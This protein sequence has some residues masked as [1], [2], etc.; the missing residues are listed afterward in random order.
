[1]VKFTRTGQNGQFALKDVPKGNFLVLI[2]YPKYADYIDELEI[3]D[4]LATIDLHTIALILKSQL[5]QEV[6]VTNKSSIRIKGDTTEFTADSFKV[7][8]GANVEELLKKLPGIQVDKNGKIT[9]QG[10]TVKKV[11]VDGE[12]FFG[13]D[14]TLVT[15]NLRADMVDKIQVFDKKSEQANFTGIDDGE[16]TKTINL[17]LKDDKKN[18]YFGKL[19][20]G[21][22]TDGYYNYQAM[23]NMFKKK[24]KLA[25]YGIASNTGK[26]GLNWE[27][28][29][30]Y[31][32]S[33]ASNFD[34]DDNQGFTYT[35]SEGNDE[36]GG[37]GG[38][39]DGKGF[40]SVLTGGLHFNNKW[41]DDR[42]SINGNYKIMQLKIHGDEQTNSQIIMPDTSYFTTQKT[43]SS[44]LVMRNRLNGSYELQIDST[45]T[46]KITADGGTDHMTT[47]SHLFSEYRAIDSSLVN[48]MD[49]TTSYISDV[50]TLN[51]SILWKKK[52]H[53]RGR[54]LSLNVRETYRD[55]T[56]DGSLYSDISY[57]G[58]GV[59]PKQIIDQHKS[60]ENKNLMLDS[61]LTYSEPLSTSSALLVNYGLVVDNSNSDRAS[62]SKGADGKYTVLDSLYSND[63]LFNV[64]TQRGGLNYN[65]AKKK[66]KF[67]FGTDIGFT[68]FKQ[69]DIPNKITTKRDFINWYPRANI[70]YKFTPNSSLWFNYYG[71]TIQPTIRE[72]QP[73]A[74]NDDPL[75]IVVGNPNLRPQFNSNFSIS[76]ND[77]KI[78]SERG[79][80]VSARANFTGD[81]IS[82]NIYFDSLGRSVSQAV[83]VN[84]NHN[85]SIYFSYNFK[86]K[87]PNINFGF[88]PNYSNN[89]YANIINNVPNITNSDN[90]SFEMYMGKYKE[91]KYGLSLSANFIYTHSNSSVQ[92]NTNTNY[93]TYNIHPDFDFYLPLNF[94]VHTDL[95]INIREKIMA[96]DKNTNVYFWNA[97]IGKKFLK[98]DALLIKVIANDILNQN[99]GFSRTVTTNNISQNTYSTIQRY[100]ML[101]AVWNFNKAGTPAPKNN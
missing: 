56:A 6:V 96:F 80:Y 49:R 28:S 81:A 47:N 100:F 63:Y 88:S 61:R 84:G 25:A 27:E 66:L 97:W 39:Y 82:S 22:G 54:T 55:N 69:E 94:Q 24:K 11:L 1:M 19:D 18:G 58:G 30:N 43:S 60:F 14:P 4:S 37:W 33:F 70:S 16:K 95:D 83:N 90:Y 35:G 7:Q 34:Y 98:N 67:N 75:N 45:S 91:K 13:D 9:A 92:S 59:S 72:I 57:Y 77:Y 68:H 23:Y 53:K 101:S 86:W 29:S 20:A 10:E 78:L 87:K 40:P 31:G 89:R 26:T 12:E 2:S 15:Q 76:Y 42:Q 52:F 41:S 71:S 73:I 38:R 3:K 85:L 74:N 93:Y 44:N 46:V 8:Q 5:L 51:S 79:I 50:N 64:F 21:V 48:Q 62:Y 32:Q 99:I 65:L 17:K 36:F